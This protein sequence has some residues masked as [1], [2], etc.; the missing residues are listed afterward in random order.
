MTDGDVIGVIPARGGSK[1]VPRKNIRDVNGVPLVAHSIRAGLDAD[2]IDTVVVS[3]DDE[4]IA[5][6][7]RSHGARIPFL[8]PPGLATDDAPTAPVITHTI[9]TLREDGEQYDVVVLLQPTSPLR[10]AGHVEEAFSRYTESDADSVIS[11]YPTY[12]TRW[13]E[14]PEGAKQLNYTDAS[15]RRQE[16]DP[17]YVV[18]GAI[19]ITGIQQF[20]EN[21]ELTAGV[22]RLYEMTERES[23]DIDT[24]FDLWLAEQTL[25]GWSEQ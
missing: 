24:P 3:T 18:N 25:A 16:R 13:K 5:D 7:A 4:E 8:R 22:T 19:Y 15:K 23:I 21:E 10:T 1:G 20:L 2:P 14:T 6:V 9:E 17:E 11:A 12:E